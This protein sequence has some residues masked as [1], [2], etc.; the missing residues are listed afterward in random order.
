MTPRTTDPTKPS[1]R[2]RGF[3]RTSSLLGTRIRQATEKRGFSE[4]RLLTHWAEIVGEEIAAVARPVSV[5]YGKGGFGATLTV[6]TTGA[7]AP[8]LQMQEP[9]LREKVNAVYGYA[10]ISRI[11]IT[12]T[13]PTGFAEGQVEFATARKAAPITPDEGCRQRAAEL[14][15]GVADDTLRKAL[16]S[17]GAQ[18]FNRKKRQSETP[19]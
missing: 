18:V 4:S 15:D 14:A 3:E 17:L 19:E 6:L 1:R 11:R 7:H 16:A 5:G 8:M 12:Q 10:A 2:M 13:A 9:R